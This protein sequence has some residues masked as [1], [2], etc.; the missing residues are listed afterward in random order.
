MQM[1]YF[2]RFNTLGD[3]PELP[4]DS[5]RF[6]LLKN[7]RRILSEAFSI[8]EEY[9]MIIYNYIELEK[10]S[11][12]TSISNMVRNYRGYFDSFDAR[13]A[14]NIKL[15]N[16]FTT[17]KLYHD[18]LVAHCA[19]C[20][21]KESG[22]Q[23]AIDLLFSTEYDKN[24]EYRFME[25]LRNY[26]Q[27]YGTAVHLVSFGSRWT[28]HD[29]QGLLEFSSSFMADKKFLSK[30]EYFKKKVLDEMPEK[31]DLISASRCYVEAISSIHTSARKMISKSINEARTVIQT[32][33]DDYKLDYKKDFVSLSAYMFDS[34]NKK[35][36]VLLILE[37]DNIRIE[38]ENRNCQLINLK[39]RYA[40]GQLKSKK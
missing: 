9:E 40:T 33:I 18:R 39:K 37:W 27:H 31:V 38:L 30:D 1:K 26:N 10:K 12:N 15:M 5:E 29:D 19:S 6:L 28:S 25:A 22:T 8:E 11:I 36:E 20:L 3:C 16:L 21:P 7:A 23:E 24:F 34:E 4:I 14:L 32:A 17:V 2:L 13:L 35:D